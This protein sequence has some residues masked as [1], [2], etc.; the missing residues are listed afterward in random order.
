MLE[1]MN[2]KSESK[3]VHSLPLI[4]MKWILADIAKLT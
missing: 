4:E 2:T 3:Q 1:A